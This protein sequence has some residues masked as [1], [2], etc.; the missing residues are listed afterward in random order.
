METVCY[1]VISNINEQRFVSSA[2][3][4]TFQ[5]EKRLQKRLH[6]LICHAECMC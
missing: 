6:T 3:G 5:K 4:V 1:V 2:V